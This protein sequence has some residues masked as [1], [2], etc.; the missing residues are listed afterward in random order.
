MAIVSGVRVCRECG[1]VWILFPK[2]CLHYGVL[3]RLLIPVSVATTPA[4]SSLIVFAAIYSTFGSC[5]RLVQAR[6]SPM[7]VFIVKRY[8]F[9]HSNA[10]IPPVA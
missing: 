9:E 1:R 4:G 10:P 3:T 6:R 7:H 2:Q 5:K 8:G